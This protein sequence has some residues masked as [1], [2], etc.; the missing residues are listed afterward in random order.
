MKQSQSPAR[1]AGVQHLIF[2]ISLLLIL[3]VLNYQYI[4]HDVSFKTFP[5]LVNMLYISESQCLHQ[6]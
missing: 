4:N 6:K 3:S 5:K 1:Y 2:N